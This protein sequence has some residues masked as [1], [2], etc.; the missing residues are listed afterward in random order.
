MYSLSN[1]CL[2]ELWWDDSIF[3][4]QFL[5]TFI[6]AIILTLD[7]SLAGVVV[8]DG[9]YEIKVEVGASFLFVKS[10]LNYL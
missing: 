7:V 2:T 1:L 5:D 9:F 3:L 6:T 4:S 10:C 8:S